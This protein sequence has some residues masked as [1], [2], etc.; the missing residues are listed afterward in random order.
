MYSKHVQG[1]IFYQFILPHDN[2]CYITV[3][4]LSYETHAYENMDY[5][6]VQSCPQTFQEWSSQASSTCSSDTYHC[7]EDEY[8]RIVEVCDVPIWI[9]AGILL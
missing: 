5:T 1:W 4:T 9:E 8:S 6:V 2:D 7:V 3:Q